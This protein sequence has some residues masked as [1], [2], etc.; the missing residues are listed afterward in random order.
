WAVA[1]AGTPLPGA[2]YRDRVRSRLYPGGLWAWL[3]RRRAYRGHPALWAG[4][5]AA[6]A[7]ALLFVAWPAAPVPAPAAAAVVVPVAPAPS[8]SVGPPSAPSETEASVYTE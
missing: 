4:A 8:P 7:A 3:A 6:A 5:G 2:G 1:A